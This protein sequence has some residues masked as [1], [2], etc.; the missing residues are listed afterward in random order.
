MYDE[1][2]KGSIDT[3]AVKELDRFGRAYL[4][5]GMYR[6]EFRKLGV[7]FI[8][9]AK[10][11]DSA[12]G[13]G[14]DFTPFR[15]VINE[16]YLRQYSK[17]IKAAYKSRGLAEKQTSSFCPYGYYKS[18]EDKNQWLA[19]SYAADIVRRV[20]LMT[21]DGKGPYQICCGLEAEKILTPG[22]Y[23]AEK[24]TGR[25]TR[26]TGWQRWIKNNW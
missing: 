2:E 1:I 9:L 13:D 15:E 14:D 20:F 5:S 17:K 19:D 24:G 10:N 3:M 11:L 7:R 6:E 23:L 12:N 22:E 16:F 21:M 26:F 25:A 8:S 18:P 4:E